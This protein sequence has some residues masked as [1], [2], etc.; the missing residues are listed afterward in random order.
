MVNGPSGA[1]GH[2]SGEYNPDQPDIEH[3]HGITVW[4]DG[5]IEE[6]FYI[7]KQRN[8]QNRTIFPDGVLVTAMQKDE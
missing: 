3:G 7:R 4:E 6:G 2:Y 5:Q 8:G 1:I